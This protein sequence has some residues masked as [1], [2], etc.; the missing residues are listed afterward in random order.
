MT[1]M[2]RVTIAMP[3]DIDK[4]ILDLKKTDD[5]VRLSY[6]E[7]VRRLLERGLKAATRDLSA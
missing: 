1:D 7:V 6:S 3:D 5:F 2:R 4:K